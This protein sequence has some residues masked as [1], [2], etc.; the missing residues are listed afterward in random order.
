MS[1]EITSIGQQMT[2]M[3]RRV[4]EIPNGS[5]QSHTAE[6]KKADAI[7]QEMDLSAA[8]E[9]IQKIADMFNRELK[10]QVSK[11][12]NRVIVKVIDS[13]TDKVIREI[14][15]AEVQRLQL[16]IKETLGLLFDESI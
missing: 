6:E 5:A 4:N 3:D 16:R 14:P 7:Q 2:A 9:Q 11:E 13:S 15:S 8:V 1:M 12:L 10:F